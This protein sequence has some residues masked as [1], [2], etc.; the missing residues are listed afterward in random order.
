MK[1]YQQ[2]PD[3]AT[4]RADVLAIVSGIAA[5]GISTTDLMTRM[6]CAKVHMD[7][8]A[9]ALKDVREADPLLTTVILKGGAFGRNLYLWHDPEL[10]RA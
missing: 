4:L 1:W 9:K 5:P 7:A 10:A 3:N 8:L 2:A 6:G